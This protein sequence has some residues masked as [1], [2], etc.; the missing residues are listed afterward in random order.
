MI[1][2]DIYKAREI[3]GIDP[4]LL[5]KPND[6]GSDG[7][8]GKYGISYQEHERRFEAMNYALCSVALE[9]LTVSDEAKSFYADYIAGNL[10]ETELDSALLG[11]H[12]IKP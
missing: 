3:I 10:T 6:A 5:Q 9:G 12:G 11:L 1:G 2:F 4:N 8:F 7:L